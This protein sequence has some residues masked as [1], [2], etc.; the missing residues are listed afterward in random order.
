MLGYKRL[1]YLNICKIRKGGNIKRRT[2]MERRKDRKT[3][4]QKDRKTERQKDRKMD[5]L[6][7]EEVKRQTDGQ[8]PDSPTSSRV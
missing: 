4:R 2:H 8:K 7:G 1:S 3:E 6:T 5:R